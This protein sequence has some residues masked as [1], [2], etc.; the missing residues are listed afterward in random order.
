[1]LFLTIDVVLVARS[2]EV[3]EKEEIRVTIASKE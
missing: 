2:E 1:M 3:D